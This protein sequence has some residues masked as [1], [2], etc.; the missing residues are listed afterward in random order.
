MDIVRLVPAFACIL[1][2]GSRQRVDQVDHMHI[3][4]RDH[5]TEFPEAD[6]LHLSR[7]ICQDNA[8]LLRYLGE[9]RK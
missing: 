7:D 6:G 4:Q 5:S 8:V 2:C 1:R 9:S 3:R